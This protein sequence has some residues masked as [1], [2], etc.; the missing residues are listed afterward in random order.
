LDQP[1]SYDV[2][3][4]DCQMP[5]LDGFA[6]TRSI[7]AR[8]AEAAGGGRVRIPIIALTAHAMA[9]DRRECLAAGMDDY[10]IKPFTK[11]D[12]LGG[13]NRAMEG[14]SASAPVAGEAQPAAEA[15]AQGAPTAP[16]RSAR[17][18][19]GASIDSSVLRRLA[20]TRDGDSSEF[21]TGIVNSYLASSATALAAMREAAS[22]G[23]PGAL[24]SAAQS[25]GLRSVQVGALGL[26]NLCKEIE[27]LGRQGSTD[28][29]GPLLDAIGP[30]FESVHEQ[31]VA[32]GFGARG[33]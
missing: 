27:A 14:Y 12:L 1:H 33:D 3:F 26:S 28:T 15:A 4:M 32:E 9:S 22:A 5:V 29:V 16:F 19:S 31:L 25:L 6:A 8:E 24:A 2:V 30:E 17:P 7:R 11:A 10:L 23:D 20:S 21:V 18:E 13:I